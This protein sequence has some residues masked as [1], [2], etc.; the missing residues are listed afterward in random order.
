MPERRSPAVRLRALLREARSLPTLLLLAL[1]AVAGVPLV[2]A[3][4]PEQH[5]EVF[6]QDVGVGA[7]VPPPSLSGPAQIVQLGNTAFDLTRVEVYGPI[8]PRLSIGPLQRPADNGPLLGPQ[9]AGDAGHAVR[10]L[11]DGFV[12]WYLWGAAGMVLAAVLGSVLMAWARLVLALRRARSRGRRPVH[13]DD[14]AGPIARMTVVAL[15][16]SLVLWGAAGAAAVQGTSAGL[17]TITSLTDLVGATQVSPSPTGPA[18]S[19]VPGAVVGDSR[20]ARIGGP[21]GPVPGGPA[22]PADGVCAR[23]VDSTAAQLSLLRGERV[24]NLACAGASVPAGLRGPQ[25]RSGVTV[26]PQVGRLKQVQGLQWVVVEIG[27]NDLAW[28]D[29]LLYCYGLATC[30]DRLSDGEFEARLATFARDVGALFSDLDALADRPRVVVTLSYD[31]F[32][33]RFD[34]ACAD[35]RGPAGAPGLDQAKI[36]L[37]AER[38]RR[39]NDVLADGAAR[40]GFTTA[41]PNLT[42]LC[43][44][45]PDGMGPDLQ[46]L[47]R[48]DP[49]HPTALGSLRTAAAV[50]AALAVDPDEP[51]RGPEG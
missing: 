17:A 45:A 38:N 46:G 34:P 11:T 33:D 50:G 31:P 9:T 24:L 20:A 5:V 13:W 27:P 36:D 23:S 12:T 37:L 4:T 30:D 39:L 7:R 16:A 6:G 44:P 14:H 26:A 18:I 35:M 15:T 29:F 51:G 40:F 49:F 48:P 19:G 25:Q 1:I 32:P 10:E 43:A 28:S 41:A 3:L 2:V 8:R 47:D 42:P 22:D 21:A